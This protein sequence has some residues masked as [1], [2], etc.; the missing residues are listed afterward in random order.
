MSIAIYTEFISPANFGENKGLLK[1]IYR[2]KKGSDEQEG[3]RQ[4]DLWQHQF[5]L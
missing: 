2:N 4:F 5:W 1:L 3:E